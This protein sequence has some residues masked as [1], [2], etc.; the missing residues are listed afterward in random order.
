MNSIGAA[1]SAAAA[2]GAAPRD[3]LA[4]LRDTA[5][6]LEGVFVAQLFKAMRETVPEDGLTHGGAGEEMFAGLLDERIAGQAPAQW[7]RGVGDALVR[8]LAPQLGPQASN[9]GAPHSGASPSDPS[10]TS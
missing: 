7:H 4:R 6:Q 10:R 8:Q 9:S 1:P 5:K 3:E 2:P